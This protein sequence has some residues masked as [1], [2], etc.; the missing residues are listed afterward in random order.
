MFAVIVL[1]IAGILADNSLDLALRFPEEV[2][3]KNYIKLNPD[4]SKVATSFSVCT[5]MKNFRNSR[6][7]HYWFSYAVPSKTNEILL[8][9]WGTN[10]LN[11]VPYTWTSAVMLKNE[12][13]HYCFTW[14]KGSQLMD[15]Y[16]NGVRVTSQKNTASNIQLGVSGTLILGQDQD[17]MAGG[18]EINQSFGGDIHQ[19]NVF[20]RKLRLEEAASMYFN[21]RCSPLPSSLVYDVAVSWDTFLR[22]QRYGAIQEVRAECRKFNER[23]FLGKVAQ[24]FLQELNTYNGS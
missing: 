4:F 19:L 13:Y 3:I 2:S 24:L 10:W 16:L 23:K 21:G 5:W 20:S 11:H 18:F 17:T 8:S 1:S 6:E 22:A 15:I 12:W 9:D 7:T 14:S